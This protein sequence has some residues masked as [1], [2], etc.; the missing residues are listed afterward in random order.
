MS[1]ARAPSSLS[2]CCSGCDKGAPCAGS[3]LGGMSVPAGFPFVVVG[4][5]MFLILKG[6]GR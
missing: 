5:I 4:V 1:Y 2:A 3:G 6:K